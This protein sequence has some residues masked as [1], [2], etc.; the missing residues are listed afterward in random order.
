MEYGPFLAFNC[1]ALTES[2][3]EAELFGYE[4]GAFTGALTR[5]IGRFEAAHRGT[6]FLDEIGELSLCIQAKLL[7]VLEQSEVDRIGG[8][9]P[10]RIDVR[11]IAVTNRNLDEAVSQ[12][13]FRADLLYR[14]NV[15][16]IHMP[17]LRERPDAYSDES[18]H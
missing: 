2:L 15:V 1:A 14:L 12:R 18:H 13:L 7:R 16:T 3:A 11:I 9:A 4:R 6:L 5:K 8:T 10:T 17:P